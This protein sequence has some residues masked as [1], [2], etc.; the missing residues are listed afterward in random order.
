M[1]CCDND[2]PLLDNYLPFI[3]ATDPHIAIPLCG[4]TK[5]CRMLL[6][7]DVVSSSS[8]IVPGHLLISLDAETA[9]AAL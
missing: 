6:L 9:A 7:S 4:P 3:I 5:L 8:S 2:A 1:Q